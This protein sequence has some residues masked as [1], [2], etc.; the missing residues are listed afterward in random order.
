[1]S[2]KFNGKTYRK[3]AEQSDPDVMQIFGA[4]IVDY[5]AEVDIIPNEACT[6]YNRERMITFALGGWVT[7]A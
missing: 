2:T 4:T 3:P 5:G 6:L 7:D 1:M